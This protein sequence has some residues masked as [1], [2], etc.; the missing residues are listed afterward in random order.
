MAVEGRNYPDIT[1]KA[2]D[3]S[4]KEL[5]QQGLSMYVEKRIDTR[6]GFFRV[7]VTGSDFIRG[8]IIPSGTEMQ[9]KAGNTVLMDGIVLQ[10]YQNEF[11]RDR[12]IEAIGKDR[13]SADIR[14]TEVQDTYIKKKSLK[15]A[16]KSILPLK[17]KIKYM[18]DISNDIIDCRL[19]KITV[20]SALEWFAYINDAIWF[21]DVGGLVFI[22]SFAD[23]T[24]VKFNVFKFS[25]IK[26]KLGKYNTGSYYCPIS[27]NKHI[28]FIETRSIGIPGVNIGDI[29][30]LDADSF[31]ITRVEQKYSISG[32]WKTH[33]FA[34]DKK[35]K[36]N[37]YLSIRKVMGTDSLKN[38][39]DARAR[40]KYDIYDDVVPIGIQH[41]PINTTKG[42][43]R[44]AWP[45]NDGLKRTAKKDAALRL[46][47]DL[48]AAIAVG[49]LR[50]MIGDKY[51]KLSVTEVN[52]TE[53]LVIEFEDGSEITKDSS[54][55]S[56]DVKG[57]M[58]IK[59]NV[60]KLNGTTPVNRTGDPVNT[61]PSLLTSWNSALRLAITTAGAAIVTPPGSGAALAQAI[62][63]AFEQLIGTNQ[64]YI[65]GPGSQKTLT[66]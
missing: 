13:Y 15:K 60:I 51:L 27:R 64:A 50:I 7:K 24:S 8:L 54:G 32:T 62:N 47:K 56:I 49:S 41:L 48:K 21:T 5:A 57:T 42:D 17:S 4:K 40:A 29:L 52:G 55:L 61:K 59:G 10:T 46:T 35:T 28:K 6:G 43:I 45:F 39:A 34:I 20:E 58:D 66:G 19:S 63:A 3:G 37:E 2:S 65:T 30:K 14:Y 33:I 31:I 12:G 38:G 36:I 44:R 25:D 9:I 26:E 16:I 23:I 22:D 11:M 18:K 1:F 53:H